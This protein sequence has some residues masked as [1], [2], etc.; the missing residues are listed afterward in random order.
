M[1]KRMDKGRQT[2]KGQ[3]GGPI[4]DLA[5]RRY[6]FLH[7]WEIGQK[8]LISEWVRNVGHYT[9]T[10]DKAKQSVKLPTLFFI[11]VDLVNNMFVSQINDIC[12]CHLDVLF[13]NDI[14]TF[15]FVQCSL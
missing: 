13:T 1:A 11:A 7:N 6:K 2:S 14:N 15:L 12:Y 5:P 8:R 3:I 10:K 4:S 9:N